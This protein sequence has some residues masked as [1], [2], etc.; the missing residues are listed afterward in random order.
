MSLYPVYFTNCCISDAV[1]IMIYKFMHSYFSVLTANV[2][3]RPGLTGT[4]IPP[5]WIYWS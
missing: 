3:G 2:P 4:R 1:M 5:F